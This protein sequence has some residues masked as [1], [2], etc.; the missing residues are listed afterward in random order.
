[1]PNQVICQ[2]CAL[3]YIGHSYQRQQ[4]PNIT[5]FRKFETKNI[6]LF[7]IKFCGGSGS[8]NNSQISKI[9]SGSR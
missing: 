5:K 6:L 2:S 7:C 4:F 9:I 1:M 8:S 3:Q